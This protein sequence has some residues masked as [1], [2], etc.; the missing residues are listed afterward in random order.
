MD[1]RIVELTAMESRFKAIVTS[2]TPATLEFIAAA[3]DAKAALAVELKG[4][5][6]FLM[7]R[8]KRLNKAAAV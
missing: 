5:G 6:A 4:D 1:A 3:L 7:E 8:L 2:V